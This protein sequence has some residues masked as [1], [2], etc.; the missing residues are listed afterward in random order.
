M[1][2]CLESEAVAIPRSLLWHGIILLVFR[3]LHSCCSVRLR[4]TE[5]YDAGR[6]ALGSLVSDA[7]PKTLHG[8]PGVAAMHNSTC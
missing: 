6:A 1:Q 4:A 2:S 3:T 8:T 5:A 7:A